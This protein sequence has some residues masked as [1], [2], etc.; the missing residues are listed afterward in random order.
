MLLLWGSAHAASSAVPAVPVPAP[1]PEPARGAPV[2]ALD[3]LGVRSYLLVPGR[4]PTGGCALVVV[5]HPRAQDAARML[6]STGVPVLTGALLQ[7]QFAVLLSGDG[8]PTTWGSPD[9]LAEV[10]QAHLEA[11]GRFRWNGRTYAL[12]LSMGGLMALRSAL[13]GSPYAVSGVAL[14]DGWSDLRG[15]WGSAMTRR[16]EINAAYGLLTAPGPELD[17]LQQAYL[18]PMLPLFV[19][20]SPDDTTVPARSNGERLFTLAHPALSE[21]VPLTGPHLGANRFSADMARRLSAFFQRLE[22]G[23]TA[24]KR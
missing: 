4:C 8:G 21:Y 17:P 19:A 5:S 23:V 15:A 9:A 12:G 22:Q 24:R 14:I 6:R 18:A 2:Q 1:V 20:A 13:P 11:T 7:A 3:V 10:A 16:E